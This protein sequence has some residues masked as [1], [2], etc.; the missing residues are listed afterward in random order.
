MEEFLIKRNAMMQN[1]LLVLVEFIIFRQKYGLF[2][3]FWVLGWNMTW[4]Y[5]EVN[6]FIS[7]Y[8]YY[9]DVI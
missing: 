8:V 2:W 5:L 7:L 6:M 3:S 9:Y 1:V 4:I